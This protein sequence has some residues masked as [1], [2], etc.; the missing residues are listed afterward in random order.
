[1]SIQKRFRVM[2]G[3]AVLS[4]GCAQAYHDYPCGCVP[5]G[6]GPEPPLPYRRYASCPTPIASRRA[7]ELQ[8][9]ASP[10]TD[11]PQ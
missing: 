10:P 5:Y 7:T 3:L 11:A 2:L 9:R 4:C 8:G 6:Y 1:M